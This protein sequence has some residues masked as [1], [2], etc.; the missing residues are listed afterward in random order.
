MLEPVKIIAVVVTT[1]AGLQ[2]I[3]AVSLPYN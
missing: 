3:L 1:A 2:T